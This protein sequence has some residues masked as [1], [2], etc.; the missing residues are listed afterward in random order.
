MNSLRPWLEAGRPAQA[1]LA[2]LGVAVG[3]SYAHFDAQPGPGL[4]AHVVIT[5]ASFAA[6]VGVNLIESGWDGIGAPPPEPGSVHSDAEWPLASR[7]A[8][9]AGGGA[10]ALAAVVGFGLVPLS[11]AA[12]LGYGIIAVALGVVRRAPVIGL[13]AL[14][15]GLGELSTVLALGPLAALAGFASQAGTGSL[16]AFLAGVPAGVIAAAV[17]FARHFTE[18]DADSRLARVTPVV[19]LGED[20]ARLVLVAGPLIAAA[21]VVAAARTGEYGPW[22]HAAVLPL[23]VAAFVGWRLPAAPERD[24]YARWQRLTLGC[25]VAALVGIVV[26]LRIAS[27]D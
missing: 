3:S 5:V 2:P 6:G 23:A 4:S 15:W 20:Q 12:A 14:G 24:D 1:L 26:S 22:A 7:E 9:V 17:L 25:A 13:D 8:L 10:L 21:A 11:G 16:G 27:P 18:Q 19:A